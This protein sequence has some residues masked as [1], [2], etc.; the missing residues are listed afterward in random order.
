M[1]QIVYSIIMIVTLALALV[2]TAAPKP[3]HGMNPV[4]KGF[5]TE[6]DDLLR[7]IV[8]CLDSGRHVVIYRDKY[9]VMQ[10]YCYE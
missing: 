8:V 4:S 2:A 9:P 5:A 3:E 10:V 7:Q 6:K 1:K